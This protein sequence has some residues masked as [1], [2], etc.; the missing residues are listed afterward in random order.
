M[1]NRQYKVIF[2]RVLNQLV[3]VSELAK[4]AGK[5]AVDS[6]ETHFSSN[7]NKINGLGVNFGKTP[8]TGVA[9][10]LMLSLG[11]V[12][13]PQA[14][15]QE[16]AIRADK[17]APG[18]QQPTVLKTA[19]GLPQVNIQTPSAGGVS[20][21]QY[22]QFD[23]A[24]QGAILNNAR[25]AA[26]T[27][28]AGWV[29][30]NPNLARGEA[31]VI[32]NE[33]NSAN[34]SRLKGYVEVAG[35]KADVV[36]ANPN[37]IH[38]DGCG[39]INAGRAT[40]TTGKAEVE[41][42]NLKGYRVQGGK[43]TV[44]EKGMDNRQAD[45]TDI[46]SEKAEIKGGVWSNKGI[47]VTTGKNKVDRTNDSV[48]YVG[49]QPAAN[50]PTTPENQSTYSVDVSQLGG[51][52][53]EKIHL[54]DNGQGL[55]V[56]NAGHIGA[57]AGDVKIDTQG[58][59]VNEGTISAHSGIDANAEKNLE[60]RGKLAS[61]QG[62][63]H[64]QAANIAHT[65]AIISQQNAVALNAKHN[66]EQSGET[67]AKGDVAYRAK[68]IT[69]DKNALIAAGITVASSAEGEKRHLDSQSVQG[70]QL[71]LA[72]EDTLLSQGRHL[73]SGHFLAI[74]KNTDLSASHSSSYSN[75][76]ESQVS[77]LNLTR[78]S[79]FSLGDTDLK[80]PQQINTEKA[81]LNAGHFTV[82]TKQ[83]N[84]QQ[85]SWLQRGSAQWSLN[86]ADG[87]DNRQGSMLSNGAFSLRVPLLQNDQGLLWAGQG[88]LS[89]HTN[90][91]HNQQGQVI[92]HTADISANSL[93]NKHGLIFATQAQLQVGELDNTQT[94]AIGE[95]P[96]LGIQAG[97]LALHT[98][99]LN[100]QAG[101][102][103]VAQSAALNVAQRLD[104]QQGEIL[105]NGRIDITN[106]ALTLMVN[107]ALGKIESATG[108]QL[109]AKGLIDEGAIKT[110]GDLDVV[111]KDSFTLNHAFAVGNNL[112]FTT[113][114][115]FVNN[116]Q[117]AVGNRAQIRGQSLH[118][119]ENAE[120]SAMQTEL[121]GKSIINRG[122]IDGVV[123][124]LQ[125][126]QVRNLGAGRIYGNHLAVE[127]E[128]IEN[129]DGATIAA[130]ERLD[131]AFNEL[132]N[133]DKSL[134]LSL[135]QT[136][137][138]RHLN[139]LHQAEGKAGVINNESATMELLGPTVAKVGKIN[140]K[141]I[142]VK[143]RIRE[144]RED[145]DLYGFEDRHS[146]TVSEWFRDGVD[147]RMHHNNGQRRNTAVFDFFDPT[148]PDVRGST[149]DYWQRKKFTRIR[150][151][152]EKYDE[153]PAKL[154]IGGDLN[155]TSDHVHNQYSHLLVGGRFTF[156]QQDIQK[157]GKEITTGSG[158]LI[159]E[160]LEA[161]LITKDIGSFY[162]YEQVRRK[163]GGGRKRLKHR[164]DFLDEK[165]RSPLAQQPP[166]TV[167]FGLVLNTIGESVA[168]T[169]TTVDAHAT[170]IQP[171]LQGA[172]LLAE[173]DT[174]ALYSGK[175]NNI[176][177]H[178]PQITIPQASLYKVNP[179]GGSVLIET[180]PRFTQKSRWLSSD[181]ML[182][183]LRNDPKNIL[184]R[185]GD[186]FYEQRLINEQ[187]NQLT[188]RRF[189]DG[190]LSDYEQYKA[191]MDNGVQ[192]ADKLNLIPGVA[193]TAAQMKELTSDM[194][195]LVKR[196]VLLKDG[197]TTQVLVPQVYI[198]GRNTDVDGSGAVISANEIVAD[199]DNVS[200]SGV[201]A[202]R[203][204]NYLH[205]NNIENNGGVLQGHQM[206]LLAK[207]RLQNLG[208][209]WRGTHVVGQGQN[210]RVLSTLTETAN[211]EHDYQKSIDRTA[212]INVGDT[213]ARGSLALYA[214]EDITL[215]GALVNVQGGAD[216][217]A[218]NRLNFATLETESKQ[219]YVND[220][221]N[222]YKLHRKQEIG[223]RLNIE[224][225]ALLEGRRSVEM[226]GVSITGNGTMRVLS[227]GDILIRESRS[228][229]DL[230]AGSKSVAKNLVNKTTTTRKH[231]HRYDLAQASE[232]DADK[233]ILQSNN[234]NVSVQ[235]SNVVAENGLWAK[236]KNIE[237]KEAE[238]RVY[239][240]D[241][242]MKQKSGLMGAGIGFT[243][244]QQK[245]ALEVDQTRL[246][247]SG[248]QVG[249]LH[250][251]TT[252][253]ADNNY[254]QTASALSA[255]KGDVNILAKNAKIQAADDKYESNMKQTF[256]QK[257]LTIAL[258][259]PILDAI[260]A[261]QGAVKSAQTMGKSK[262]SRVNAMAVANTAYSSVQAGRAV[263][264]LA[265]MG[266]GA[267]Q[268]GGDSS[269]IK[270]SITYGQQQS[271]SKTH[272][273]GK[274]AAKSQVNADGKVNI[275]ATAVG[276]DANIDIIGSDVSGKQGTTLIADNQ[277]NIKAA[278]Q[279][280]ME[281]STNKSS[282]FNVGVAIAIGKG[283][284][285]GLT[286]GGNYGKGYGN[287][288]EVSYV[289]SHVGDSNS[290]T[291][292]QAGGDA[293]LIGAQ[294][295]GKRVEVS[296]ENLNIES[297]QDK[298]TYDGKQMNVS[299]SVTV[300]YGV[301][302]GGSYN[303]SK[304]HS[305]YASVNEQAGIFAGD[306]GYD[307]EVRNHTELKGAIIT[308]T[309]QAENASR[310]RLSTETLAYS[311]I[312]NHANY[313][314][315]SIGVAGGFALGGGKSMAKDVGRVKLMELGTNY[316][317]KGRG[318][319]E[320]SDT[321]GTGKLTLNKAIGFG[322]DSD[323]ANS[324]TRAGINTNN[325]VIRNESLQFDKTGK[326]PQELLTSI[327][328]D[329]TTDS[330][331]KNFG[332]LDNHFDKDR[333]QKEL[334]LQV[335][336]T[337][338]FDKNRQDAKDFVLRKA[339]ELFLEA[340]KER[341][342]HGGHETMKSKAL[343][344]KAHDLSQWVSYVDTAL[345]AF[346]GFELGGL[347]T[348]VAQ[349][350]GQGADYHR[351]AVEHVSNGQV[352]KVDCSGAAAQYYCRDGSGEN[353]VKA[354]ITGNSL[355]YT[356]KDKES[357]WD[358]DAMEIYNVEDIQSVDGKNVVI[359]NPGIYNSK[360]EAFRN[361]VKQNPNA[362]ASGNL[363]VVVNNPTY[364]AIPFLSEV[365]FH[366]SYDK[367]NEVFGGR[368]PLT[369][370]EKAND[371]IYRHAAQNNVKLEQSNHSRG[372]LTG[373]VSLQYTNRKYLD[374]DGKPIPVP[375]EKVRL[376]GAAAN[377]ER[378]YEVLE[379][380]NY[381][382]ENGISTTL[383]QASHNQDFVTIPVGGNKAT[384]GN[385]NGLCYSHSG[386]Y[387]K[388][389]KKELVDREGNIILNNDGNPVINPEYREY[390]R[391]W[392]DDKSNYSAP[393]ILVKDKDGNF[394]YIPINQGFGTIEY[395]GRKYY[396]N[397]Y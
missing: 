238:N 186:G 390:M 46:I 110:R 176:K 106:P 115:D 352:Y 151:V 20:R 247:A 82:E 392:G 80:A 342:E 370:A 357:G 137:I 394:H 313:S 27:Q 307:V 348:S 292:I 201:I 39:V 344:G 79:I 366:A 1:N 333:V 13:M 101:G 330:V 143:V 384:G 311:N 125:G 42:G 180:D 66:I 371:V 158:K 257:G 290:K 343:E 183:A 156:N 31:K 149:G 375:L 35:K 26:Q 353:S 25:K 323:H 327:R 163:P 380:N 5:A 223:N 232:F 288:D 160:D 334:A 250:G 96:H 157:S 260:N 315:T 316:Q 227:D 159:N 22:T 48:V 56:R 129:L 123:N 72:A 168:N 47:K 340:Q 224:A 14:Q 295:I 376:V 341:Y 77:P 246:S 121:Q 135:G 200:N 131:L 54:V 7:S 111:L 240:Q 195:W 103:Y 85:G 67:L 212:M 133:R 228:Y 243:I 17:S 355:D 361:A 58:R 289:A 141:D 87:L 126:E 50:N 339:D 230:S 215:K 102:I 345:G 206:Y 229:E 254:T 178:L 385:C 354:A 360:Y 286:V 167:R 391:L 108:M 369:N 271:E 45:Y 264:G 171:T 291:V 61:R 382:N 118:N 258:T 383:G 99:H 33:V 280:H 241:I 356:P 60:N 249:S 165:V 70:A 350:I 259:S 119:N 93:T 94:K 83:L 253:I 23:V 184:K 154:L 18:N 396:E 217:R 152:P 239:S 193:L 214:N 52:Y 364:E 189:L 16:M 8:L 351:N 278:E 124:Q 231:E 142:H 211:T 202:G 287:G 358:G 220:A 388:V 37:G 198:V 188:G 362:A 251:N 98:A 302:V 379:R 312:E 373:S 32:L 332:K 222:Y 97:T 30:G 29:Q 162:R 81:N 252:I 298:A 199:L 132:L 276:K 208:G 140:N 205:A 64:V 284:S 11:F 139:E 381:V 245:Q 204:L 155:L 24:E 109:Q 233:V 75:Y 92:A 150:Y 185:L 329:I 146:K 191:L 12:W 337:Q 187:I 105:S 374:K 297:L 120:I 84:N 78:A 272:V 153:A 128:R 273:E 234:G 294:V 335:E 145:F 36:I 147:G 4:S 242:E 281:R 210:I 194:V 308:S 213:H 367:M 107:N 263:A 127:A 91:L 164:R 269:G 262:S 324:V 363:Y 148:K 144:E 266:A 321:E 279:T 209:E 192:Y 62:K 296:A 314:G 57:S 10:A 244:G 197:S 138:G 325:I 368:L 196:D 19:N 310:N 322:H 134:V 235:G 114:G 256:E 40:L 347:V 53:A 219:N 49:E 277:V 179:Q 174:D 299:G 365:I 372:S 3:V 318:I 181:Y 306:D 301:A 326:A 89:A 283:V 275:V 386:Y 68:Q 267:G 309:Q 166:E 207:Q 9:F 117:L 74:A 338:A 63:I 15:A 226:K 175:V 122:L 261:V 104:N 203:H 59:I 237:I 190:Y 113:E 172:K 130:R 389:P 95:T 216:I 86:L 173:S 116:T 320:Q 73:A 359:S 112:T 274:T 248:S 221:D 397:I 328:T 317:S 136:V 265:G 44:G 349:V 282:G 2:S 336:V 378:F 170:A 76:L 177:T 41:N 285:A 6:V 21:N 182:K 346:W 268:S 377:A 69:A 218:G 169:G 71:T 51:M 293:N 270:I 305:D 28:M 395:G 300:G 303:R 100:N 34:P 387:G 88:V 161:Q 90:K 38:C 55:G 255:I 43:V 225:N 331:G 319:L 393:N 236:G 304:I 65:G